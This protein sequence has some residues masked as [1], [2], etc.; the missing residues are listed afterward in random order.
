VDSENIITM[1][2]ELIVPRDQPHDLIRAAG[3][4]LF[5]SSRRGP[6]KV[7][8]VYRE[9]R[10]D[11]TFPKGKLDEGESFEEAALREVVEET[12]ITAR[13]QRFIGS[14]NY[15]HRKGRPKIVAYYLMDVISGEFAPNE[16]VD[17]LRWVT[18]DEAFELLTWDRDQELIELLRLLPEFRA[19]AS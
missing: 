4:V 15:T 9:A 11:W 1:N 10:G 17:E 18:L 3:G 19:T 12:G 6:D 7:A 5:R 2:A 8:V 16:E 13:I 14:T